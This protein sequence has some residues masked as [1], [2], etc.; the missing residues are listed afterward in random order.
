M[1]AVAEVGVGQAAQ[2]REVSAADRAE[3][4]AMYGKFEPKAASLGLPPRSEADKWIDGL[5]KFPNFVALV[6]GKLVGHAVLCH[7]GD[8]G[9]VA[10]FVLQDFRDRGIGR[11]LLAALLDRA[12][13]LGLRNVWGMTEPDNL[14]VLRMA[15]SLGFEQDWQKDPYLFSL[16]LS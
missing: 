16:N 6:G 5:S 13:V 14:P 3:I 1:S 11:Q 2:I 15:R 12:R 7:E 8:A 9:E 10:V 4:L